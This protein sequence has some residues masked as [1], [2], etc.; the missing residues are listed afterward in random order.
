M[1]IE[2]A[3]CSRS[4]QLF[5]HTKQSFKKLHSNHNNSAITL[6]SFQIIV[7]MVN[8]NTKDY[9]ERNVKQ[10][11]LFESMKLSYLSIAILTGKCH[12]CFTVQEWKYASN[13]VLNVHTY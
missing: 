3:Y 10:L 5:Q 11:T 6:I 13:T 8:V 12:G 1:V 7:R 9:N 2:T 4:L